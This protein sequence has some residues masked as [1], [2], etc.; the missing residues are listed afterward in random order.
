MPSF[1]GVAPVFPRVNKEKP[2]SRSTAD[3]ASDRLGCE[4]DSTREAA[5]IDPVSAIFNI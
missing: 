2:S 1:V 3:T 5:T 4:T